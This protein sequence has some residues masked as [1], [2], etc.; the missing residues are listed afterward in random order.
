M[1]KDAAAVSTFAKGRGS[2]AHGF[3]ISATADGAIDTL[4]QSCGVGA[5]EPDPPP[6]PL[7]Q[8]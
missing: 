1:D 6:A 5:V 2:E 3:A 7:P 4:V 8:P